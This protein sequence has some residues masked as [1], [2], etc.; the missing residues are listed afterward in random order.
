[1]RSSCLWGPVVYINGLAIG[2]NGRRQVR[3]FYG[4][5]EEFVPGLKNRVGHLGHNESQA[6][7][8]RTAVGGLNSDQISINHLYWC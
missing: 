8:I 6:R 7:A 4:R 3:S 1:M 5:Q 2:R